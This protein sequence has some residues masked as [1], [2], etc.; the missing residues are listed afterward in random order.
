M[1]R[2]LGSLGP[3]EARA[4]EAS[5]AFVALPPWQGRDGC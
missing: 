5:V 3:G 2:T 4:S 1:V